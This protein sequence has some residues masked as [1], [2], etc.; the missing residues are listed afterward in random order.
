MTESIIPI[1]FPGCFLAYFTF[2]NYIYHGSLDNKYLHYLDINI[3]IRTGSIG[4][5]GSSSKSGNHDNRISS[6]W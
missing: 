4:I 1:N 2:G 6:D 3:L 5:A